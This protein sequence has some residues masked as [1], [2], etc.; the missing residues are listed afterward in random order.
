MVQEQAVPVGGDVVGTGDGDV[1]RVHVGHLAP[2]G[3]RA[4]QPV[5]G[6]ERDPGGEE[7][8]SPQP[9]VAAESTHAGDRSNPKP[10]IPLTSLA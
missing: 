4:H 10:L 7:E 1:G 2:V 8:H 9:A 3:R 6:R 5:E